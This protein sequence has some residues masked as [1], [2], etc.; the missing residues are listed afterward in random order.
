MDKLR[1]IYYFNYFQ[2]IL[3]VM[4]EVD[5]E[6]RYKKVKIMVNLLLYLV[7]FYDFF[8]YFFLIIDNFILY[9]LG[10]LVIIL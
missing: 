2:S 10:M 3:E 8:F 9:I 5:Y 4:E 1:V 7:F 6:L